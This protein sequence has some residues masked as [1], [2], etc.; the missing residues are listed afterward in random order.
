MKTLLQ[1]IISDFTCW[2]QPLSLWRFPEVLS[3]GRQTLKHNYTSEF[4]SSPS[5]SGQPKEHAHTGT[6]RLKKKKR[7]WKKVCMLCRKAGQRM[8]ILTYFSLLAGEAAAITA[9]QAQETSRSPAKTAAA[10]PLPDA[11]CTVPS[12][13]QCWGIVLLPGHRDHNRLV[14]QLMKSGW[15]EVTEGPGFIFYACIQL[16]C[17]CLP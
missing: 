8:Q 17:Q 2:D 7:T 10:M 14:Q 13:L 9:L 1:A 6:A 4:M 5:D 3:E 15:T 12:S 16:F 11:G